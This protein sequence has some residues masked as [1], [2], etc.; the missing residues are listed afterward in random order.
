[1]STLFAGLIP[2]AARIIC[3]GAARALRGLHVTVAAAGCA[4]ALLAWGG[5]APLLVVVTLLPPSSRCPRHLPA[6]FILN[7]FR[8]TVVGALEERRAAPEQ[9]DRTQQDAVMA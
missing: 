9:A 6:V 2:R 5:L 8:N 4:A 7:G 3:A 1:M